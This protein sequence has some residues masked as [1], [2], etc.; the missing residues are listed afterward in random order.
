MALSKGIGVRFSELKDNHESAQCWEWN[1]QR[2]RTYTRFGVLPNGESFGVSRT[3]TQENYYARDVVI[4]STDGEI[5][6]CGWI[7]PDG[8]IG[9]HYPEPKVMVASPSAKTIAWFGGGELWVWLQDKELQRFT[10]GSTKRVDMPDDA[11][12][13]DARM[14]ENGTLDLWCEGGVRYVY[15][16]DEDVLLC[17]YHASDLCKSADGGAIVPSS[18]VTRVVGIYSEQEFFRECMDACLRAFP[19]VAGFLIEGDFTVEGW[20]LCGMHAR[21]LRFAPEV[22]CIGEGE[23]A[24]LGELKRV[25]IPATVQMV[26]S[27]AFEWCRK[28]TDL[29]IEGDLSRVACWHEDAFKNCPCEGEYLELHRKAAAEEL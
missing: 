2:A 5:R 24:V 13:L 29:V 15:S 10:S 17:G 8:G 22:E 27:C 18:R 21:E 16:C 6:A 23:F 1:R 20:E 7:F 14:N 25:V 19:E 11:V 12:V 4:V 9:N 26:D 3:P 28:L